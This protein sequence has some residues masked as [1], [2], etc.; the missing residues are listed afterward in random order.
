MEGL[1]L[2]LD[3]GTTTIKGLVFDKATAKEIS[4][5]FVLNKQSRFGEDVITRI[6]YSLKSPENLKNLKAAVTK[7]IN[8]LINKLLKNSPYKSP[9]IKEAT[10]VCNT[11]MHHLF[12]GL[13]AASL[14]KPPYRAL[15]KSETTLKAKELNIDI[16]QD[17]LVTILPNIGGFVG[18]DAI[19]VIIACDI[20]KSE[21]VKLAIDIGTNG[22]VILGSSDEILVTSTAAGPA[23]EAKY[24]SCGMSATEGAIEKVDINKD[25]SVKFKV[26]GNGPPKGI[27]GSG[28]I[29]LV[30][31][32]LKRNIVDSTGRMKQ[33]NF[34]LYK[35]GK[36]KIYITQADIRKMQ[37]AK[38]AIYAA[39]KV[40]M[41][42]L[43]IGIDKISKVYLT[44]SFG[45]SINAANA[46]SIGLIPKVSA[47]KA[48][49]IKDAALKG[50][51]MYVSSKEIQSKLTSILSK[52]KK[53]QLVRKDFT[54]IYADSM[55]F[56]S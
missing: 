36:N 22:E 20:Y 35:K 7:S 3:I 2:L 52:I 17:A 29:D 44:G 26:I 34:I 40:L 55:G 14:V 24:I 16:N 31:E 33:Q 4:R 10:V 38:A 50:A 54:D 53:I 49:F 18:S 23:F 5:S 12:L 8:E 6:D 15:Q 1:S 9:D 39:V 32:M 27:C 48:V 19:G 42:Q 13:S 45:N 47:S 43:G 41:R 21:S 25:G 11:A 28:L 46:A 56:L 37:L 51:K 30:A